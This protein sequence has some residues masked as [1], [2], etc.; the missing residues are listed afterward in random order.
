METIVSRAQ[1]NYRH[2]LRA[3]RKASVLPGPG[4]HAD[5]VF[6]R[7]KLGG[8]AAWITIRNTKICGTITDKQHSLIR[9]SVYTGLLEFA[10]ASP[11]KM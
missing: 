5:G 2:H 3:A 7:A 9:A 4:C 11:R 1:A 10:N 8:A 6:F